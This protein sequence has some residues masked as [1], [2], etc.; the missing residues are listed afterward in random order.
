MDL[1]SY[2]NISLKPIV[3]SANT[4]KFNDDKD[5]REVPTKSQ[6]ERHA[7][8]PSVIKEE[9][10]ENDDHDESVLQHTNSK[11]RGTRSSRAIESS[12]RNNTAPKY[13]PIIG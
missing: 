12:I 11:K 2:M 1:A 9:M 5:F 4:D 13:E 7:Q 6:L 3:E 10:N 8:Q